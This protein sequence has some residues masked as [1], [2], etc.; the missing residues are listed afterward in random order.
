MPIHKY[1]YVCM[2]VCMFSC[3]NVRMCDACLH[4]CMYVAKMCGCM[5]ACMCARMNERSYVCTCVY[6][7]ADTYLS[8]YL[9]MN[10]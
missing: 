10:V 7:Y 6:I 2:F 5:H 3:M 8:V 9:S 4:T 1:L